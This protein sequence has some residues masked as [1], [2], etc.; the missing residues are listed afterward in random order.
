MSPEQSEIPIYLFD[1][2]IHPQDRATKVKNE[3]ENRGLR[4][5]LFRTFT[6]LKQ[7]FQDKTINRE[8]LF[9]M[10]STIEEFGKTYT[11]KDTLP[12]ITGMGRVKPRN[13]MPGSGGRHGYSNNEMFRVWLE[14]AKNYICTMEQMGIAATGLGGNPEKVAKSIERYYRTL[15]PTLGEGQGPGSLR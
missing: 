12:W 3:L 11:F 8:G 10:D 1:D 6:E 7:A 2:D 4:V 5:E 9:V 13:L 14:D 15:H